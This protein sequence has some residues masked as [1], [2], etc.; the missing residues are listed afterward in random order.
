[1][2]KWTLCFILVLAVLL[3]GSVNANENGFVTGDRVD[4]AI[5]VGND[6]F[7]SW[8]SPPAFFWEGTGFPVASDS[9]PFYFSDESTTCVYVTDAFIPGDRFEVYD[10]SALIGT[11][12]VVATGTSS[13][14]E[15]PVIAYGMSEFSHG[16]FELAPGRHS[17]ELVTIAGWNPQSPSG[18]GYIMVQRGS[19][20]GTVPA[21]EFPSI[22]L[23]IGMILG[24][25]FIVYSLRKRND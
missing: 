20:P 1:M 19:C 10:N 3:I 24:L 5:V 7:T 2:K 6:W 22:A 15:D 23:P 4:P 16:Y 11:T 12:P 25:A 9:D 17:L 21:P 13:L 8:D 18:R 14:T